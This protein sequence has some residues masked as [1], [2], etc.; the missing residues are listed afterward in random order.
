M[1]Y[2]MGM[3]IGRNTAELIW[4]IYIL[5]TNTVHNNFVHVA[6]TIRMPSKNRPLYASSNADR[7]PLSCWGIGG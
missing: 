6:I 1:C 5:V 2:T 7:R 4:D 3:M